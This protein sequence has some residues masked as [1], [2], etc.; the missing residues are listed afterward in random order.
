MASEV[1]FDIVSLSYSLKFLFLY[2]EIVGKSLLN[3]TIGGG[4]SS[5]NKDKEPCLRLR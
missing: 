1:Q 4:G 3:S 5:G 2:L